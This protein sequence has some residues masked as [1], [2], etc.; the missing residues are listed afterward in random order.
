MSLEV[1]RGAG[2]EGLVYR[3]ENVMALFTERRGAAGG[4]V[5][6]RMAAPVVECVVMKRW[7]G[8]R[9]LGG[10]WGFVIAAVVVVVVWC[11]GSVV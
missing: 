10:C 7:M 11:G 8:R 1:E 3:R 9:V 5:V 2:K 4:M 6:A